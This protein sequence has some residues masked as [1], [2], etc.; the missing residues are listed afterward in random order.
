MMAI[1]RGSVEA[2]RSVLGAILRDATAYAAVAL[3]LS[4]RDFSNSIHRLIFESMV[5]LAEA[6]EP[7]DVA[8]VSEAVRE[9]G[10]VQATEAAADLAKLM[11]SA[12]AGKLLS[13]AA[14]VRK[15]AYHREL[16]IAALDLHHA[17]ADGD[18]EII[19]EMRGALEAVPERG[20]LRAPPSVAQWWDAPPPVP[21]L[22]GMDGAAGPAALVRDILLAEGEVA[23]LSGAGG[24]GKS[25]VTLQWALAAA[26]GDGSALGF[27]VRR[28]PV[29]LVS[30]EDSPVR[31]AQR[32]RAIGATRA[33]CAEIRVLEAPGSL[34]VCDRDGQHA[35]PM[36]RYLW[37]QAAVMRAQLIVLDPAHEL[38]E[39]ADEPGAGVVRRLIGDLSQMAAK[40]GAAVLIV[41]HDTKAARSAGGD[42]P[43]PGAVG[44]SRAW[45]DRPRAGLYVVRN[46]E[47]GK[48]RTLRCFKAN[49]GPAGWKVNV[50]ERT[51]ASGKFGGFEFDDL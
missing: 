38:I 31:I 32:L 18:P 16:D 40:I 44:G 6:G 43:G 20:D 37:D 1:M 7:L 21:V 15:R 25:F 45:T 49:H 50:R 27:G 26:R 12:A 42:D 35:A 39:G 13:A 3:W 51:N 41:T 11:E 48:Q 22:W 29:L 10:S 2:E 34:H 33:D 9:R 17:I 4:P 19:T 8:T 46:E 36:W 23:V 14:E 5:A 30:Y 24:V 28:G 47:L